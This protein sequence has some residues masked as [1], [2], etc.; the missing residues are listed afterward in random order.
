MKTSDFTASN[1]GIDMK[2]DKETVVMSSNVIFSVT[3]DVKNSGEMRLE[4][5][6]VKI[7]GNFENDGMFSMNEKTSIARIIEAMNNANP[8]TA[9]IDK[10]FVELHKETEDKNRWQKA[11]EYIKNNVKL[12]FSINFVGGIPQV[13][14]K[15]SN[16]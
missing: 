1:D 9:S 2:I 4:D 14:F 12:E 10:L 5:T 15:I 7:N 13:Q 16:K 3:G 8:N 6:D 11:I